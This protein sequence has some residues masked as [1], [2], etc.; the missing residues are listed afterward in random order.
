MQFIESLQKELEFLRQFPPTVILAAA[1]AVLLLLALAAA[2]IFLRRILFARRL[3]AVLANPG[4]V[5]ELIR[6]RYSPGALIRRS[7][8]IE[9]MAEKHGPEVVRLTGVDQ[10][11]I[12]RLEAARSRRMLGRVLRHAPGEGLFVCFK[13]ALEAPAL[14]SDLIRWLDRS[15]DLLTIRRIAMS[16]LGHS[17]DGAKARW[18]F[19]EKL[20]QVRELAGDPEWGARFF[21]MQILVGDDDPKSLRALWEAFH[22]S[23]PLVRKT[24]IERF[25]AENS[26]ARD[27]LYGHLMEAYLRDPTFEVRQSAKIRLHGEFAERYQLETEGLG[28]AEVLHVLEQLS[29]GLKD[30]ENF[31]LG[32]L[33]DDNLELRLLAA[34]FLDRCGTLQRLC[35]EVDLGDRDGLERNFKLLEKAGEVNIHGYLAGCLAET[36]NPAALLVCARVIQH[37]GAP[38]HLVTALAGRV[39]QFYTGQANFIEA[40]RTTVVCVAGRGGQDALDLLAGELKARVGD[41][42]TMEVLLAEMPA[43]GGPLL[44]DPVMALFR[45]PD[46]PY[47]PQV[48]ETLKRFPPSQIV[49][50]LLSLIRTPWR[51]LPVFVRIE[52]VRLLGELELSYCLQTVLENMWVLPGEDAREF[53]GVLANYPRKLLLKKVEA[54]LDT[55]DSRIRA[56]IIAALPATGDDRFFGHIRNI[57]KDVDPDVRIAGIW[58]LTEFEGVEWS[59]DDYAILRDPVARVREEAARALGTVASKPMLDAMESRLADPD[60]PASVKTAIIEGLAHSQAPA[61]V[62]ILVEGLARDDNP[63]RD[64]IVNALSR[65]ISSE[66]L[67]R[68]FEHLK[69]A[70]PP[71]REELTAAFKAMGEAGGHAM[72]GLLREEIASL[73]PFIMEVLES[74]GH[75]EYQIRRLSNKD[76]AVRRRAAEFLTSVSSLSALRGLVLAAKDPDEEVRIHVVKA[77]EKLTSKEGRQLLESLGNDPSSKVRRYTLWA[78]ERIKAKNL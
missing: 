47:R 33:S 72:A 76:V 15:G 78:L 20:D 39:F 74:S 65:K 30:D 54:M 42:R 60:E 63:F 53:M 32:Y 61:A 40:Y 5:E 24:L 21:A 70:G 38:A 19:R 34:E 4:L 68:L 69:D 48:R 18:V 12:A 8:Q 50:P 7:G 49:P 13:V 41:A 27:R 23:H 67:A 55:S 64:E 45:D 29:T 22:D 14:A 62:D 73:R 1:A 75:T 58:A 17:F 71:L 59:E 3:R 10:L 37:P 52:A 11:W 36:E 25:R 6:G 57:L 44:L 51:A 16:G 35:L 26:E 31:A 28:E 43:S 9:K 77:L 2:A 66:Q 46:N 56:S